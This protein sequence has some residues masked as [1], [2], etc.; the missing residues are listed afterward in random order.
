[1]IINIQEGKMVKKIDIDGFITGVKKIKVGKF[2]ECLICSGMDDKHNYS[3]YL[4]SF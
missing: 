2:G 1:M 4:F 3:I